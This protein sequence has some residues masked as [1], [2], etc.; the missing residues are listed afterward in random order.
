MYD[1]WNK[2]WQAG[3][4]PWTRKRPVTY[5]IHSK[6]YDKCQ[7]SRITQH[8]F[9]ILQNIDTKKKPPS[10]SCV[11]IYRCVDMM[12]CWYACEVGGC[13]INLNVC[14]WGVWNFGKIEWRV[15]L[16][17]CWI[18]IEC[19]LKQPCS[20]CKKKHPNCCTREFVQSWF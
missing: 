2:S 9:V 4:L 18:N 19:A 14:C 11:C 3:Y 15:V 12:F 10:S 6:Y 16:L 7:S 1:K 17:I 20:I 13:L 5:R 8:R